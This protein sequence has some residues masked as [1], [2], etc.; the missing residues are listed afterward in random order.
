MIILL[1]ICIFIV[2]WIGFG[3]YRIYLQLSY[4][5]G[6]LSYRLSICPW[7]RFFNFEFYEE[8]ASH[9]FSIRLGKK[10]VYAK[11]IRF[12]SR[13]HKQKEAGTSRKR[14]LQRKY[15]LKCLLRQGRHRFYPTIGAVIQ[16]IRFRRLD[17]KGELGLKT[18]SATGIAFGWIQSLEYLF[19]G[20][21]NIDLK[22]DFS[23]QKAEYSLNLQLQCIVAVLLWRIILAAANAGWIYLKCKI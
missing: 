20:K 5:S 10:K 18:P 1:Y 11:R 6:Q 16:S 8:T 9:F 17:L 19:S 7:V 3:C 22:P 14:S 13:D 21:V 2:L 4:L 23:Q 12:T 15:S